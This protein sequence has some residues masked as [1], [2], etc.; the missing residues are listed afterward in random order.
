[1]SNGIFMRIDV[2]LQ[3]NAYNGTIKYLSIKLIDKFKNTSGSKTC[4]LAR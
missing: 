4:N 2:K 1:M 3:S